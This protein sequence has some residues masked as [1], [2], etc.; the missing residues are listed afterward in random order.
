VA[1]KDQRRGGHRLVEFTKT[2]APGRAGA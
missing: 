1:Q 2:C